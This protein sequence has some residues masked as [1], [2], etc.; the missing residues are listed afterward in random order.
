MLLGYSRQAYYQAKKYEQQLAYEGELIIKEVLKHRE[1]L[2]HLGT[3]KLLGKLEPFLREHNFSIGRDGLYNLLREKDLLV[4]KRKRKGSI[5]TFSKHSYRKY[6]NVSKGFIPNAANQLWV[7]DITYIHIGSGFGYLSIITDQYSH[8]IVGFCL[9]KT[10]ETKGPL[11]ALKMA[12]D[13]ADSLKKLIH[14]SDRGVQY[15]CGDYVKILKDEHIKISM[16]EKG[17]PLENPVAE[18]VNGILKVEL[19]EKA[20]PNFSA[21]Q[22][23]IAKAISTYNYYRP[24]NSIDD[25]TPVEAH[26]MNGYIPKKWKNYYQIKQQKKKEAECL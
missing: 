1:L 4:R 2:K 3:R 13:G 6:P 20:Y 18:R 19:L 11:L 24:H 7:S 21:A 14:H 26:Q 12:M 9:F 10:L 23:A 17:D 16:T 15:C 22:I 8:K 25:L 5:T